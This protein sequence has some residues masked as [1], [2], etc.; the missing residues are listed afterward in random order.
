M[1]QRSA[2][3]Q[4]ANTAWHITSLQSKVHFLDDKSSQFREILRQYWAEQIAG[5]SMLEDG[6][7]E[8]KA[9][10]FKKRKLLKLEVKLMHKF[11]TKLRQIERKYLRGGANTN[12]DN[13]QSQQHQQQQQQLNGGGFDVWSSWN[14]AMMSPYG[15]E[16]KSE[17]MKPTSVH[18]KLERLLYKLNKWKIKFG[19]IGDINVVPSPLINS[20]LTGGVQKKWEE[21][22]F[23]IDANSNEEAKKEEEAEEE[24][25]PRTKLIEAIQQIKKKPTA[26]VCFLNE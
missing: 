9:I 12:N 2:N 5:M 15:V 19:R 4:A 1:Q 24:Q 3:P 13:N 14:E 7:G 20:H 26:K 22:V 6:V 23:V 25:Q 21:F 11:H 16:E 17:C 8:E 18:Q 10:E